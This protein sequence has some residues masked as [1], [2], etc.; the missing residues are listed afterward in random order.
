MGIEGANSRI[1][2]AGNG[3]IV[4]II[5]EAFPGD[6]QEQESNA[7]LIAEAGTVYNESKMTPR[8]MLEK[9]KL[10]QTTIDQ[11]REIA[12]TLKSDTEYSKVQVNIPK[13][14]DNG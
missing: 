9:I 10:Y 13:E 12:E 11:L 7:Q 5:Y 3:E 1:I 14:T 8:Q 2:R 4:T 6:W